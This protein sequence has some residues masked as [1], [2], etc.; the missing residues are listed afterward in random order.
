MKIRI[1]FRKFGMMKFIGH[2]DMMRYFQKCMRRA[3]IDIA[4]TQ[5][6]NPHQIMSFASPLGLGLTSDGEYM[7]IE[8]NTSRSSHESLKVLNEVMAEGVQ[9]LEYRE[10][11]EIAKNAMSL[12][13]AADYTVSLKEDDARAAC[14]ISDEVLSKALHDF[15]SKQTEILITKQTKKSERVLNLK[16]LI[17]ELKAIQEEPSIFMKICT[18]STDNIKPE[19]VMEAFFEY[20]RENGIC[21][22]SFP[23]MAVKIHR[24]EVYAKLENNDTEFIPLGNLGKDII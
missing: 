14:D 4:Y 18:G 6:F 21:D 24:N 3:E 8:V 5:G 16:P 15:L 17:Y 19:L 13:A 22:F 1:K 10:L 2:L 23:P 11:P 20:G 7:D 12:V 9:V